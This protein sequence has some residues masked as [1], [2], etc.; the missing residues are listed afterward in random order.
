MVT[1][2]TFMV[3]ST[4]CGFYVAALFSVCGPEYILSLA[5]DALHTNE[6]EKYGSEE[7]AKS[8]KPFSREA[9]KTGRLRH[10]SSTEAFAFAMLLTAEPRQSDIRDDSNINRKG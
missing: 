1:L 7:H 10:A 9:P 3:L 5:V 8:L 2:V 4:V 6:L